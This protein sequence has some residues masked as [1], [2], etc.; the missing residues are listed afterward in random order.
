[1]SLLE[2]LSHT[3]NPAVLL[4]DFGSASEALEE[5]L[6]LMLP[7]ATR[8]RIALFKHPVRRRQ[9]RWGRILAGA[10]ARV[11]GAELIEEPPYAPYLLK[12]GRRIALCIAH[13]GTSVAL[14]IACES[15][16]VMGLDLETL[17]P[18]R[19]IEG[20][21]RMSFGEAADAVAAE[22]LACGNAEPFFRAWGL[23]ESE[24][25]LNRGNP[26]FRLGLDAEGRP[27]VFDPEGRRLRA[28]H[29]AH[30]DLRLT[31][32]TGTLSPVISRASPADVKAVLL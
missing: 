10:A 2:Q 23:K 27:A 14:G 16:P 22:C 17:R 29:S 20:M 31:V 30:D 12:D 25:K 5:S 26:G 9:T 7:D 21:C 4:L 6:A 28:A 13:T 18:V 32:L 11:L 8:A 15:D 3:Q 24:V 19:S 1:M